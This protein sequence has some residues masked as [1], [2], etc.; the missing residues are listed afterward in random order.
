MVADLA[1]LAV[2]G[3]V[4]DEACSLGERGQEVPAEVGEALDADRAGEPGQRP[5]QPGDDGRSRGGVH[6]DVPGAAVCGVVGQCGVTG[7]GASRVAPHSLEILVHHETTGAP[8]HLDGEYERDEAEQAAYL[9]TLIEIF[10]DEGVDGTFVH[11]FALPSLPHRPDGD[12]RH[13]LDLAS[14]GIVKVYDGRNGLT[15]PDMPWE[16]K[17]AFA[18]VADQ[19]AGRTPAF[20]TPSEGGA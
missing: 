1:D 18:A 20:P 11:L 19:Y 5:L 8:L 2:A 17:E 9:R 7:R 14:P 3:F 13:D 6:V 12:P 16:P 15:Y 4:V 10:D